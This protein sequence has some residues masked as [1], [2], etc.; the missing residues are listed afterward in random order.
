MVDEYARIIER[1]IRLIDAALPPRRHSMENGQH[2]IKSKAGAISGK[3]LYRIAI[4]S[5]NARIV[6]MSGGKLPARI[7]ISHAASAA[8]AKAAVVPSFHDTNRVPTT[9]VK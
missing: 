8:S 6:Q 1:H 5:P 2:I 9:V 3:A 4:V 7:P